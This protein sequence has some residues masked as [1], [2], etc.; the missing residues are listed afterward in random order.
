MN[1]KDDLFEGENTDGNFN[2]TNNERLSDVQRQHNSSGLG[3][4]NIESESRIHEGIQNG[5]GIR[6]SESESLTTSSSNI[7]SL[8]SI[9]P[10]QNEATFAATTNSSDDEIKAAR[11]IGSRSN[12]NNDEQQQFFTSIKRGDVGNVGHQPSKL[13]IL[14]SNDFKFLDVN[15]FATPVKRWE[16][17]L[18][19]I[20]VLKNKDIS[21][22]TEED[23]KALARFT[24][25]GGL[26]NAITGSG[27]FSED[28]T[29]D[30]LKALVSKEEYNLIER[31][32]LDSYYTS[33]ELVEALWESLDHIGINNN[34]MP[35]NILEPSAGTGNMFKY[36]PDNNTLQNARI[37]S[38][39]LDKTTADIYQGLFPSDNHALLN[40]PFQE[41]SSA[42]LSSSFDVVI[43][44]PPFGTHRVFDSSSKFNN[45]TIH[46]YFIG[47]S[48]EKLREGGVGAFIVTSS[49]LDQSRVV[50]GGKNSGLVNE[51]L[52]GAVRKLIAEDN[53]FLGAVRLPNNAFKHTSTSVVTDIVFFKKGEAHDLAFGEKWITTKPVELEGIGNINSPSSATQ[54]RLGGALDIAVSDNHIQVNEY[55]VNNPDHILGQ[56]GWKRDQYGNKVFDCVPDGRDLK[57]AIVNIIKTKFTPNTYTPKTQQTIEQVKKDPNEL[58]IPVDTLSEALSAVP[59][60]TLQ[61]NDKEAFV[62]GENLTHEGQVLAVIRKIPLS[63]PMLKRFK[64][65]IDVRDSLNR[66]MDAERSLDDSTTNQLLIE[67]YR[68][69]LNDSYDKH[70]EKHGF[71]NSRSSVEISKYCTEIYKVRALEKNFKTKVDKKKAK[72][73]GLKESPE[74]AEKS[75]IFFKRLIKPRKDETIVA[76]PTEAYIASLNNHGAV[77]IEY[78]KSFF[79]ESEQESVI[80]T[81][82][83]DSYIF[84]QPKDDGSIEFIT[85]EKLLT[86]NVVNKLSEYQ[87]LNRLDDSNLYEKAIKVLEQ[88]QP[89]KI[90]AIEISVN[91]GAPYIGADLVQQFFEEELGQRWTGFKVALHEETGTWSVKADLRGFRND[92]PGVYQKYFIPEIAPKHMITAILHQKPIAAY[93]NVPLGNGKTEKVFLPDETAIANT[94][95]EVLRKDFGEWLFKNPE[96]RKLI[97]DKYNATYNTFAK[98]QYDGS[99]LTLDGLNPAIQ[100]R[101]HQKNAIWRAV[102]QGNTLFDHTVGA[103]KTFATIASVME[104]K[105]M[106]L[107]KKPLVIVPNHILAQWQND[108]KYAYPNANILVPTPQDMEKS[109]REQFFGRIALNDWDAVI[110]THSQFTHIDAPYENQKKLL[111]KELELME[112]LHESE[113][114][115]F[116]KSQKEKDQA[117]KGLIKRKDTVARKLAELEETYSSSEIFDFA[118][119]GVDFLAVDELHMYKNLYITTKMAGVAG[120]G[121]LNGSGKAFDLYSK[122]QYLQDNHNGQGLLGATG[123]PISNTIAEMYTLQRYFQRGGLQERNIGSFDAWAATFGQTVSSWELDA[124]GVNYKITNRF[125]KFQNVPELQRM[126]REFADVIS[127]EDIMK[128]VKDLVPKLAGGRPVNIVSE[129]SDDVANYIGILDPITKQ[130]NKGSIIY[131]MM[132]P[133]ED[134]RLNNMLACTTDARKA[135]LDYRLVDPMAEDYEGSKANLLADK[136]TEIYNAT[137]EVK[138]TQLVFCDLSVPKHHSQNQS[139]S[140]QDEVKYEGEGNEEKEIKQVTA[141]LNQNEDDDGQTKSSGNLNDIFEPEVSSFDMYSDI[142]K[143]LM[144]KGIP[145]NEIAFIHDAHTDALKAE[146]F[147]R[148]NSGEVRVLIGSTAKMGAGTNVQERAVAIHH[149]DCPWRP[150][151]LEQRNGRVIRQGN[152]LHKADPENFRIQEYRYAQKG[153][154][155]SRMW[156]VQEVKSLGLEGFRKANDPN[157][158]VIDDCSTDS[159]NAS[160]MKALASGNPLILLEVQLKQELQKYQALRTAY[161]AKQHNLQDTVLTYSQAEKRIEQLNSKLAASKDY[162]LTPDEVAFINSDNPNPDFD[163]TRTISI[164]TGG[165]KK[166]HSVHPTSQSKENQEKEANLLADLMAEFGKPQP[167][168]QHSL[169]LDNVMEYRGLMVS[170]SRWANKQDRTLSFVISLHTKDGIE[171]TDNVAR[172]VYRVRPNQNKELIPKP[173]TFLNNIDKFLYDLEHNIDRS[174]REQQGYIDVRENA[175]A[176]LEVPFEHEELHNALEFDSK[177]IIAELNKQSE[178]VNYVSSFKPT[179]YEV[180]NKLGIDLGLEKRAEDKKETEIIIEE[181]AMDENYFSNLN[182]IMKSKVSEDIIIEQDKEQQKL[183]EDETKPAELLDI[184]QDEKSANK[185]VI[186]DAVDNAINIANSQIKESSSRPYV[187]S[188]KS[189]FTRNEESILFKQFGLVQTASD[190]QFPVGTTANVV[191][192]E[193]HSNPLPILMQRLRGIFDEYA[194]TQSLKNLVA[195]GVIANATDSA[196]SADKIGKFSDIHGEAGFYVDRITEYVADVTNRSRSLYSSEQLKLNPN[197]MDC[198]ERVDQLL[199]RYEAIGKEITETNKVGNSRYAQKLSFSIKE[200]LIDVASYSRELSEDYHRRLNDVDNVWKKYLFELEKQ[201]SFSAKLEADRAERLANRTAMILPEFEQTDLLLSTE[202]PIIQPVVD[203]ADDD[204]IEEPIKLSEEESKAISKQVKELARELQIRNQLFSK[205]DGRNSIDRFDIEKS[206]ELTDQLSSLIPLVEKGVERYLAYSEYSASLVYQK[207]GQRELEFWNNNVPEIEGSSYYQISQNPFIICS[208][209][210]EP[211][212]DT[213]TRINSLIKEYNETGKLTY[214]E[215]YEDINLGLLSANDKKIPE[216]LVESLATLKK[217][218]DDSFTKHKSH[219]ENINLMQ[220]MAFNNEFPKNANGKLGAGCETSTGSF[221]PTIEIQRNYVRMMGFQQAFSDAKNLTKSMRDMVASGRKPNKDTH[222]ASIRETFRFLLENNNRRADQLVIN[223][224]KKLMVEDISNNDPRYLTEAEQSTINSKPKEISN[225]AELSAH[226]SEISKEKAEEVQNAVLNQMNTYNTDLLIRVLDDNKN[227]TYHLGVISE[228]KRKAVE[229]AIESLNQRDLTA[230]Q[231]QSLANSQLYFDSLDELS[232]GVPLTVVIDNMPKTILHEVVRGAALNVGEESNAIFAEDF[233][234]ILNEKQVS[235][236]SEELAKSYDHYLG[237]LNQKLNIFED[238]EVDFIDEFNQH[239]D[240]AINEMIKEGT[241]KNHDDLVSKIEEFHNYYEESDYVAIHKKIDTATFL[242]EMSEHIESHG[243]LL[244]SAFYNQPSTEIVQYLDLIKDDLI[245]ENFINPTS[246]QNEAL[247]MAH[248]LDHHNVALKVEEIDMLA[249][250]HGWNL[251][252]SQLDSESIQKTSFIKSN[253][254]RDV[255]SSKQFGNGQAFLDL[256]SKESYGQLSQRLTGLEKELEEDNTLSKPNVLSELEYLIKMNNTLNPRMKDESKGSDIELSDLVDKVNALTNKFNASL[257]LSENDVDSMPYYVVDYRIQHIAN[258]A[259]FEN[260]YDDAT[261]LELKIITQST[262]ED[263]GD[264]ISKSFKIMN[265]YENYKENNSVISIQEEMD[266][267]RKSSSSAQDGFALVHVLKEA[268]AYEIGA[269]IEGISNELK[270]TGEIAKPEVLEAIR[271][272]L[273]GRSDFEED[274]EFVDFEDT[275]D[276]LIVLEQDIRVSYEKKLAS[277]TEEQVSSKY[278]KPAVILKAIKSEPLEHSIIRLNAIK[279]ELLDTGDIKVREVLHNVQVNI[280][281]KSLEYLKMDL[282]K[283]DYLQKVLDRATNVFTE[284]LDVLAVTISK[285]KLDATENTEETINNTEDKVEQLFTEVIS[286]VEVEIQQPIENNKIDENA[287]LKDRIDYLDSF[288]ANTLVTKDLITSEEFVSIAN[289]LIKPDTINDIE[290]LLYLCDTIERIESSASKILS[291]PESNDFG[292]N[293]LANIKNIIETDP[294]IVSS[295][296][297][298]NYE[299]HDLNSES[300]TQLSFRAEWLANELMTTNEL[301]N[302]N[303]AYN[304]IVALEE[305]EDYHSNNTPKLESSLNILNQFLFA[306]REDTQKTEPTNG[307]DIQNAFKPIYENMQKIENAGFAVLIDINHNGATEALNELDDFNLNKIESS[308]VEHSSNITKTIE[309]LNK[310]GAMDS[311]SYTHSIREIQISKN[312]MQQQLHQLKDKFKNNTDNTLTS[313]KNRAD[314]EKYLKVSDKPFI[315]RIKTISD[316]KVDVVKPEVIMA[317]N[318]AHNAEVK[319]TQAQTTNLTSPMSI[320]RNRAKIGMKAN[321]AKTAPIVKENQSTNAKQEKIL[322]PDNQR[323]KNIQLIHK[324]NPNAFLVSAPEEEQRKA[325]VMMFTLNQ[326]SPENLKLM[327]SEFQ[328]F[329]KICN[330]GRVPEIKVEKLAKFDTTKSNTKKTP[331]TPKR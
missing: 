204:L 248:S 273:T 48:L 161:L 186:N 111:E 168:Q 317:N 301:L 231:Q 234:K 9:E 89:E 72:K 31:S 324:Q 214:P 44:N 129:R 278:K 175:K 316:S 7:G 101:A 306:S 244:L 80:N 150:S 131:R 102:Q 65:Y 254:P 331:P 40:M 11:E 60:G 76:T 69:E 195:A 2:N 323:M 249:K 237:I 49:F 307:I 28:H 258:K 272:E 114:S 144:E 282:D 223:D 192:R 41:T 294:S 137:T 208:V 240:L 53:T 191:H 233:T 78:I 98:V 216:E 42:N 158:R 295:E 105:R 181:L 322:L 142:L 106:G 302:E 147:A 327:V 194:D 138:G 283:N 104:L 34:E 154:Y 21:E 70:V 296:Q 172:P 259:Q 182:R 88:N 271:V 135:G 136:V 17:N 66:L 200:K 90:P 188:I 27:A 84:P 6:E 130:Y 219:S 36:A 220:V 305:H 32:S 279:K 199:E 196:I 185:I 308:I 133:R 263:M 35:I 63:E 164:F 268:S 251:I 110:M 246:L 178:D 310:M 265:T 26:T 325:L 290:D 180:K 148:V 125:A 276:A 115:V 184:K 107:K 100:M 315:E 61:V 247:L 91:M 165:E 46:N 179:S 274:M 153:T 163:A 212:E 300:F 156:Q 304:V 210:V 201:E 47:S 81:L 108:W 285:P 261:K 13:P 54:G 217:A 86:G 218:F 176:E 123:T 189:E 5:T 187:A 92:N 309:M 227:S 228:E 93:E 287:S 77:N 23:Q 24:G 79:K 3:T 202:E 103:G 162:L 20:K 298:D 215:V 291:D 122:V 151:D 326:H 112:E 56:V 255:G 242:L 299:N 134:I 67:S 203:N 51:E 25:W 264:L 173:Q 68:K 59:I 314:I 121:D 250:E 320:M 232:S 120:L 58:W 281:Q 10:K 146:L 99:H 64:S 313:I 117:R 293:M 211:I 260:E 87:E 275:A 145:Q 16:L 329:A 37:T 245:S 55:F 83:D 289:G 174:V 230:S 8:D 50:K 170:V 97:E 256:I 167:P 14:S 19:A 140:I 149:L 280:N 29:D 277:P 118:D 127:N 143:K 284:V 160:E 311:T 225:I 330:A 241:H 235:M 95:A 209:M 71:M 319:A 205:R 128:D 270:N 74:V 38:V 132:N 297:Q 85:L 22:Y 116:D 159:A 328:S 155:D 193:V 12:N 126:Y 4:D 141:G 169:E 15:T 262:R 39:E 96:R 269:R 243:G 43:S 139:V 303:I 292:N 183:V 222:N 57:E 30:V 33:H 82:L 238:I 94:K 252:A 197:F 318:M 321:E 236:P 229:D 124:S 253:M 119:L 62:R 52:T 226:L 45:K 1:T 166:T 312:T 113:Q 177:Q 75:D 239:L 267:Y 206:S 257:A 224:M 286:P 207:E 266:K 73:H 18:E 190:L 171:L 288:I 198:D 152:K 213:Q 157:I 109:N 221:N